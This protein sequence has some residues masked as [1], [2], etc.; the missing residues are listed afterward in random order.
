MAW[1]S[2]ATAW[3][4][5]PT[6]CGVLN[7][8]DLIKQTNKNCQSQ[9][10]KSIYRKHIFSFSFLNPRHSDSTVPV[11][12]GV[13]VWFPRDATTGPTGKDEGRCSD[14]H[15]WAG[16]RAQFDTLNPKVTLK[17]ENYTFVGKEIPHYFNWPSRNK[18]L[19][20]KATQKKHAS[21]D[22]S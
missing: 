8:V 20:T 2:E 4:W 9:G 3:C 21:I 16:S 1:R 11:L 14:L 10:W 17:Y 22:V 7:V 18:S 19:P 15:N 12:F 13:G 6:S 5:L